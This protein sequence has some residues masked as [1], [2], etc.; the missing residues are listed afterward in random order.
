M[1]WAQFPAGA[2]KRLFYLSHHVQTGS[3][4]HPAS[5]AW[6]YISTHTYV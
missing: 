2:L 4:A 5:D 3:V 6:S 1:T